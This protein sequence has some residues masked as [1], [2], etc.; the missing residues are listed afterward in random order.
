MTDESV[1]IDDHEPPPGVILWFK[2][3]SGFLS[4]IYLLCVGVSFIF[5]LVDPGE[6]EMDPVAAKLAGAGLLLLGLVLF[7]ACLLPLF[8]PRK[9]WLWIYDLVIIC[10]GFTGICF[11]PACIPLMIFWLKPETKEYFGKR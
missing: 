6:L 8:L 5:L 1:F 11:W 7:V 9:P 10:F 2:L 4:F 3:Y